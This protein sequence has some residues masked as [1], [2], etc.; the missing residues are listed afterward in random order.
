MDR[1][2]VSWLRA[3]HAGID[4]RLDLRPLTTVQTAGLRLLDPVEHPIYDVQA[5]Q[6]RHAVQARRDPLRISIPTSDE[7][8]PL[9]GLAYPYLLFHISGFMVVRLTV[10]SWE[11]DSPSMRSPETLRALHRRL[12]DVTLD[13]DAELG[14]PDVKWNLRSILNWI[15]LEAFD[16]I[17]GL[18]SDLK[19]LPATALEDRRGALGLATLT[20]RGYIAFPY[21]VLAG[22]HYEAGVAEAAREPGKDWVCRL[23]GE[24]DET[25]ADMRDL[26]PESRTVAWYASEMQSL[27]VTIGRSPVSDLV[28]LEPGRLQLAEFLALR[29]GALRSLQRDTQLVLAEGRTLTRNRIDEWRRIAVTTSDDYVLHDDTGPIVS[30]LRNYFR[31]NERVRDPEPLREQVT[32]NIGAFQERIDIA[33]QRAGI[34]LGVLF[35]VVAA[36]SLSPIAKQLLAVG[37]GLSPS[38][39]EKFAS[40]YPW[41]SVAIDVGIVVV[42]GGAALAL[43]RRFSGRLPSR[44]VRK[45]FR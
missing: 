29:R 4:P 42:L 45:A 7:A 9:E 21:P 2:T 39:S 30:T 38:T 44:G 40:R 20:D 25:E 37:L 11:L 17:R 36:L 28:C 34:V 26:A 32:R 14:A 19:S 10:P 31:D 22:T 3:Y 1:F 5:L 16:R 15:W 18:P 33:G 13:I 41:W 6:R 23:L 24:P 8:G 35:G 12:W 27:V 43:F